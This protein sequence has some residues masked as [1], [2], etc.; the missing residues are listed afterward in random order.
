[1]NAIQSSVPSHA[2][3]NPEVSD[4]AFI[5]PGAVIVCDVRIAEHASVWYGCVVRG[6]VQQIVIGARSNI[7]DGVVIHASTGGN[8]TVIG[9][10]V[11]VGHSAVLH[12]CTIEDGAFVGIGAVVLDGAT[13]MS[14]GM[15]AAGAVLTPRKTVG[16]G[17]L[18]AGNPAKLLRNLND[19]ESAGMQR[20][21]LRYM[22]LAEHYRTHQPINYRMRMEQAA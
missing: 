8:P 6:D 12:A 11:T 10:D 16:P 19:D 7:Q 2:F 5:A 13:V 1:M 4:K 15:L 22:A 18:W 14:G 20:N 3:R 17:E 9:A 21:V